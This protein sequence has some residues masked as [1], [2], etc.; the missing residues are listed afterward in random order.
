MKTDQHVERSKRA[1]KKSR[2][3]KRRPRATFIG[4]RPLKFQMFLRGQ[5]VDVK[6]LPVVNTTTHVNFEITIT[7]E[8]KLLD[9]VLT[10]AERAEIGRAAGT[11]TEAETSH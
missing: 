7:H 6:V 10:R 8:G 5:H 1:R 2:P 4:T 9:W 11:H 3:A